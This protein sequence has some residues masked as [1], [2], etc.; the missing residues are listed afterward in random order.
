MHTSG[1]FLGIKNKQ[2]TI[3][4]CTTNIIKCMKTDAHPQS[5]HAQPH[6]AQGENTAVD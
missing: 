1:G 2:K 5:A 6:M 4:L 3:T